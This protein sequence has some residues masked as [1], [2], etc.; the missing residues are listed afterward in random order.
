MQRVN[1]MRVGI[2]RP[3]ICDAVAL[4]ST[5]PMDTRLSGSPNAIRLLLTEVHL[6]SVYH[7]MIS[8]FTREVFAIAVDVVRSHNSDYFSGHHFTTVGYFRYELT[9]WVRR[10]V[11]V[12]LHIDFQPFLAAELM[13]TPPHW[14]RVI[15][16]MSCTCTPR[17]HEKTFCT[18]TGEKKCRHM[19]QLLYWFLQRCAATQRTTTLGVKSNESQFVRFSTRQDQQQQQQQ[20]RRLRED[21]L[22]PLMKSTVEKQTEKKEEDEDEKTVNNKK[23]TATATVKKNKNKKMRRDEGDYCSLPL[24][25]VGTTGS[26]K[27]ASQ[28]GEGKVQPSNVDGDVSLLEFAALL[29]IT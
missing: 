9:S 14:S 20:K 26:K 22:T 28:T 16:Q 21:R 24:Q 3:V 2:T 4:V 17:R 6:S 27:D 23:K 13:A 18:E 1:H 29:G 25:V 8:F 7:F 10:H 5:I 15:R 11:L 12:T 19:A